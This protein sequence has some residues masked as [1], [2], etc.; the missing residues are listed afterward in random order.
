MVD[1]IVAAT[2]YDGYILYPYR[3]S[4][5]KNQVRWTF[6]GVFPR[7]YSEAVGGTD[8]HVATTECLLRGGDDARVEVRVRFLHV[9]TRTATRL[10]EPLPQPPLPGPLPELE[11]V[12]TVDVDGVTHRSWEEAAERELDAGTRTLSALFAEPQRLSLRVD[13]GSEAQ[14]L[15]DSDGSVTAALLR[16]HEPLVVN[17]EIGAERLTGD[18]AKVRVSISNVSP[19]SAAQI[20]DRNAALRHALVSTHVMLGAANGTWLSLADPPADAD[21]AAAAC[22]N[23][24]LWPVLVGEPGSADTILASPIILEDHPQLA[25]ESPGDLFDATEIDEILSLRILTLTDAE[26]EEMRSADERARAMLDRTESLTQ[27]D[28][29]RMH[30]AVRSTRP[31]IGG[32]P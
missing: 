28:F 29:M 4:S 16:G 10:L 20:A 13:A 2:L 19:V 11:R 8:P 30:G 32:G 24:G 3:A 27:D 7:A 1:R 25:P 23:V 26:K 14:W 9:V 31:H 17:L 12:A 18:I 6:G 22:C 5:V 21:E 15:R